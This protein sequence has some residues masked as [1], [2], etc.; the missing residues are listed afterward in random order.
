MG[1]PDWRFFFRLR[2]RAIAETHPFPGGIRVVL[3]NRWRWHRGECR[4][5]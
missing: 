1:D 2:C 4:C 5:E 3:C